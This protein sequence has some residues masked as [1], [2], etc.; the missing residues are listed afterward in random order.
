LVCGF[1]FVTGRLDAEAVVTGM[2]ELMRVEKQQE[3]SRE[4][5][6]EIRTKQADLRRK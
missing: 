5:V 4:V 3:K 2:K 6:T 1:D